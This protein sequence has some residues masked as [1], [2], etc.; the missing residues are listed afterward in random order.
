[1]ALRRPK[2]ARR[3]GATLFELRSALDDFKLRGEPARAALSWCPE[4]ARAELIQT[5]PEL[6]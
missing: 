1:M 4:L 5:D 6:G 2:L 3:H